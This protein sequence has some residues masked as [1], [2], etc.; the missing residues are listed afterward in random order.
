MVVTERVDLG[1]GAK[2][3]RALLAEHR[4]DAPVVGDAVFADLALNRLQPLAHQFR[5]RRRELL[6]HRVPVFARL[7]AGVEHLVFDAH[8]SVMEGSLGVLPRR[9][10]VADRD[11]FLAR[12]ALIDNDF[13]ADACPT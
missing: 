12:A 3:L 10:M 2:A 13:P 4:L 8:M 11:H 5:R 1:E 6:E 7:P 9:L